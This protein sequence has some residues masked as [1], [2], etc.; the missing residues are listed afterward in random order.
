MV[1]Q[2]KDKKHKQTGGGNP[3]RGIF[4][5]QTPQELLE[6]A[7]KK[8]KKLS[9]PTGGIKS[10]FLQRKK[11]VIFRFENFCKVLVNRLN[12]I[13]KRYPSIDTMHQF[14]KSTLQIY[15]SLDEVKKALAKIQGASKLITSLFRTYKSKLRAIRPLSPEKE[16]VRRAFREL[17]KVK[18]EAYGRVTSVVKKLRKELDLL[19]YTVKML[20]KLPDINPNLFTVIV[21]GPPNTGKSSLVKAISTAKVEIAS[22]PFT[23]KNITLG[24]MEIDFNS[25]SRELVQIADTPGLFDRPVEERRKEELLAITALKTIANMVIFLFDIS[26]QAALKPNEQLAVLDDVIKVFKD[27]KMIYPVGNKAD[28]LDETTLNS[29]KEG[30]KKRGF[31]KGK[32]FTI[33]VI[34]KKGLENVIK[35]IKKNLQAYLG[36]GDE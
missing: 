19:I 4:L 10:A 27:R 8:S 7:F 13:V 2:N 23:T 30:L 16:H 34:E 11:I 33:S 15:A 29:I 24:H 1:V 9:P 12:S 14:Y 25:V 3:F 22:Y 21:V 32:F 17:E 36:V 35:L 18:R 28:I 20:K 31:S 5:P 26:N 6:I